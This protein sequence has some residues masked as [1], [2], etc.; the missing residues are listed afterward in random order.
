MASII[1]GMADLRACKAPDT[2]TTLGLGSCVGICLYDGNR[3]IIGMAHIML[4]D[5]SGY[6]GQNRAKF[7]DSAAVELLQLMMSLGANRAALVAKLAGG[8]HMFSGSTNNVLKVGER[9]VAA[10]QRALAQLRIPVKASDTGGTHGRT[11]E[12]L[13]DTGNL[14]IR[15]VGA[16]EKVI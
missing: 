8:A 13:P 4:P 7:A 14:R 6:A 1:V 11:I 15:T 12:L 9:N 2:L 3:K 5:S 16:G 10:C